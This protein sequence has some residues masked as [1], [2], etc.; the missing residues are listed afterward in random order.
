VC[1][2]KVLSRGRTPMT[3]E[4]GLDVIELQRALKQ[5]VVPEVQLTNRQV[6]CCTPIGVDVF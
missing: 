6:I 3:Q 5:G 1:I 4:H 2:N